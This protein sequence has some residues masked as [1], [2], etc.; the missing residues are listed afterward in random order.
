MNCPHCDFIVNDN[1]E[2]CP[3]CGGEMSVHKDLA[4]ENTFGPI[5]TFI[6]AEEKGAKPKSE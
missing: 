4:A 6:S 2:V 1:T 5:D 3:K